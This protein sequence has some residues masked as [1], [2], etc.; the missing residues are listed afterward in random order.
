MKNTEDASISTDAE[1]ILVLEPATLPPSF[2][3]HIAT[4]AIGSEDNTAT[5]GYDLFVNAKIGCDRTTIF[6]DQESIDVEIEVRKA[7]VRLEFVHC[8]PRWGKAYFTL[9]K[10]ERTQLQSENQVS[11]NAS[12]TFGPSKAGASI[13]N[14]SAQVDKSSNQRPEFVHSRIE[15]IEFGDYRRENKGGFHPVRSYVGWRIIHNDGAL[16][17]GV[18][19][20]LRVKR[21][22]IK[23]S[24]I[25][26]NSKSTF[27][28]LYDQLISSQ[29]ST[30]SKKLDLFKKLMET[31]VFRGLQRSS[32]NEYAT[33]SV[34][35]ILVS[36]EDDLSVLP[37]DSEPRRLTIP[38]NLLI[39]LLTAREGTET[40][41]YN[42]ILVSLDEKRRIERLEFVP[43][44]SYTET[45][46]V[47][48]ELA[49]LHTNNPEIPSL[50]SIANKYSKNAI[51]ELSVLGIIKRSG[52]LYY[53]Q[54]PFPALDY[55]EAFET[56]VRAQNTIKKTI[57][58]LSSNPEIS[59]V[60][61][62]ER[63]AEFLGRSHW[64]K[65]TCQRNGMQ[66]KNWAR[67][68]GS[69]TKRRPKSISDDDLPILIDM[70]RKGIP[71]DE[72]ARS[73]QV[74]SE[75]VRSR[76]RKLKREKKL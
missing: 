20:R 53:F 40:D 36:V 28:R 2:D 13:G 16:R 61:I 33:L 67:Q 15:L 3:D 62:G 69:E 65:S 21:H 37:S 49:I 11:N 6:A 7:E 58:I 35:G 9:F 75:T 55:N 71:A 57:E 76:I 70:Y 46:Q 64:K 63:I 12:V 41:V 14:T 60:E 26:T 5:G 18:L 74:V 23:I 43:Q 66:L 45:L 48:R 47:F 19:A 32:E 4:V 30:A 27:S 50:D 1:R 72:I 42:E 17:S 73:F 59:H 34:S 39:R 22:W 38:A 8:K 54:N 31:L 52:G 56:I 51:S 25:R 68:R 29:T 10:D 44:A 24:D